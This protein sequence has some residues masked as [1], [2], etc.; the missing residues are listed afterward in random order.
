ML[1]RLIGIDDPVFNDQYLYYQ[2]FVHAV[3]RDIEYGGLGSGFPGCSVRASRRSHK[4]TE[5]PVDV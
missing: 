3:I 1:N 5:I 2:I 4:H